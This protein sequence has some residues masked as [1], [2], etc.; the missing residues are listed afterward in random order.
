MVELGAWP[1]LPI[2]KY[3]AKLGQIDREELLQSFNLGVGMIVCPRR[4]RKDA[5]AELKRRREKFYLIGRIQRGDTGKARL[6][7]SGAL[8]L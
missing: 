2:F 7:Y 3:L 5:E 6:V 4:K 8:Y 1:V